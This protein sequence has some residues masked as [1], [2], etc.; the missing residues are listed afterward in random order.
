MCKNGVKVWKSKQNTNHLR[1]GFIIISLIQMSFVMA[2]TTSFSLHDQ[3]ANSK[4]TSFIEIKINDNTRGIGGLIQ[5]DFDQDGDLDVVGAG[6]Q[7]NQIVMY[8]NKTN[9][10]LGWLKVVIQNNVYSAHSVYTGDFD[11]DGDLDIVAAAYVGQPGVFWLRNNGGFPISWSKFP[12]A[13][14]FVNAHEVF[15]FDVDMD[16]DLDILAASSDLNTIAWWKNEDAD[17]TEW[18]MQIISNEVELAKSVRAGDIDGDGDKDVIGVA[19]TTHDILWWENSGEQPIEWIK[20]VVDPNFIGAHKV[21]LIDMDN[22]EDLDVLCA[23]YLGHQVAWWRNTFQD[24][25]V[26][27]KELIGSGVINACAADAKDLDEDGDLDVIATAQGSDEVIIW[28]NENGLATSWTRDVLSS[29]LE[30]PWP[31]LLCDI[32]GD[33]DI[34]V[35]SAS[36]HNGNEEVFWWKNDLIS[37]LNEYENKSDSV[38]VNCYPNPAKEFT[39]L[40]IYLPLKEHF[41]IEVSDLKGALIYSDD[42]SFSS[43]GDNYI[44]LKLEQFTPGNYQINIITDSGL[45]AQSRLI[46]IQ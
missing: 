17:T 9:E 16:S 15:A 41:K 22:D 31:L 12:V 23:G 38:K 36:S 11:E 43:K 13:Q 46:K 32:D 8:E 24:S 44:T 14:T 34:D 19:I 20:H 40:K 1:I 45:K 25:I 21:E 37:S 6:L 2:Q 10:S 35:F 7:D 29:N 4:Y 39:V 26:W 30:R 28:Y 18:E 42:I 5:G 33:S 3:V 27:E